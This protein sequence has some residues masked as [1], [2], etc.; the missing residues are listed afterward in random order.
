MGI[1]MA[2]HGRFGRISTGLNV[3]I[4]LSI[5][6]HALVE[7]NAKCG[8]QPRRLGDRCVGCREPQIDLRLTASNASIAEAARLAS[9]F[10]VAF[11]QGMD[12]NGKIDADIQ[13][14]GDA[15][16]P[17]MNGHLDAH[18]LVI[19]GKDLP[20]PVKIGSVNLILTSDTIRSNDFTASTGS[21]SV[22]VNFSL[23]HYTTP[24]S[25]IDASLR[26]PNARIGEILNIAKAYGVSAADGMSGED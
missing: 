26:A 4:D 13:A 18:E 17:A 24:N 12:V 8:C 21:T 19:S 9:A 7:G 22:T 14:R 6:I 11:N 5:H 15:S 23:A 25:V 16:K 1:E 2:I 10:G 3:R 20:Q